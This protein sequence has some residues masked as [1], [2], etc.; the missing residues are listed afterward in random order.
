[1]QHYYVTKKQPKQ[2]HAGSKA[3]DDADK[4]M[5]ELGYKEI[6]IYSVVKGNLL[7]K[8][9]KNLLSL[10]SLYKIKKESVVVVEHPLY[11]NDYYL[12]ILN[13]LKKRRK[14]KVVFLIHD[15]ETIRNFFPG[16]KM[17]R[18]VEKEILEFADCLIVHN[19]KMKESINQKFHYPN[20][21]MV[22][23]GI[24]DYLCNKISQNEAIKQTD[25]LSITIAGNLI[26]TKSGY[27]YE[28]AEKLKNIDFNLYGVNFAGEE[29]D[30][31][32]YKGSINAD[33]LPNI[34]QGSYGLVWDGTSIESCSGMAGNYL[35]V[36]D[37]HKFSLYVAAG[38]PII[39][40]KQAAL[41][42]FVEKNQI[43]ITINSLSELNAK[44]CNVT[45]KEY[46]DFRL[47]LRELKMHVR[48]G[49]FLK[50]ALRKVDAI[51]R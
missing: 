4:I 9:I 17:M 16:D 36:N 26:K 30:N 31:C 21:K 14:I 37:P 6:S 48:N 11:I 51:L 15:F 2:N 42:D 10:L 38:L 20:N 18:Q 43:G 29:L 28:M 23:L 35:K 33:D 19:E 46:N 5:S 3:V 12:K 41:A 1:M 8:K 39:I 47:N 13:G 34:I 22:V 24:F 7:I 40:W 50:E 45:D 25:H 32:H 44:L 27:I 49:D